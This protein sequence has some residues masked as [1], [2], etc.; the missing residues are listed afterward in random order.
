MA[1]TQIRG[2]NQI[3]DTTITK[4]KL[5]ADFL[6]GSNL[7]ITNGNEDATITG[8]VNPSSAQ[9]AA[10]KS[11]VDALVD[12]SLKSPEA[13]NPTTAGGASADI[14]S[15]ADQGGNTWRYTITDGNITDLGI[16]DSVLI[17]NSTNAAND[18]T[19]T[20]T[21]TNSSTYF[22]VTNASGVAEVTSPATYQISGSYPTEYDSAAVEKGDSFRITSAGTIGN[23]TV[24]AEDLLIALIDTPGQTNTN[25]M[26]AESNRDQATETVLGLVELSTQAE[27]DA[28]TN[29]TTAIT[30]LKLDTYITN[31]GIASLAF[32]N[33]LTNTAGAVKLGGT[34]TG[35]TTI[36]TGDNTLSIES[37]TF[38]GSTII[39]KN[40]FSATV[41]NAVT[42]SSLSASLVTV[43]DGT[44]SSIAVTPS[45]MVVTDNNNTKGLTYNGAYKANFTTYSLV[46]K[47]YV[48][49]TITAA[50][51]TDGAGLLLTGTTLNVGAGNG[52]TVGTDTISVNQ[53]VTS[54]GDIAPVSVGTNGVGL[55]VTVLDGDH[56]T[57]TWN[58]SNSTPDATPT[59]AADTDDLTAHLKGID[60]KF[61]T[62]AIKLTPHY[63][64]TPAI[65]DGVATIAALTNLGS[66][67]TNKV[68]NERVY[69]NGLRQNE[70]SG[71]DYQINNTT[72]V[73][74]F[75]FTLT[76]ADIVTVDYD[77]QDA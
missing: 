76:T 3:K 5:V 53:D 43:D 52:I 4:A 75:E 36:A 6:A 27:A 10:T 63:G 61:A 2:S 45:N 37:T 55:D 35:A 30:P 32:E 23:V 11:Y 14:A 15:I 49:T 9:D 77:K 44:I 59:A 42:V 48:D 28:G 40:H 74:T 24:N 7:N 58:P 66:H 64:E 57:I 67:A 22:D 12:A 65:T 47:D 62:I 1:I 21:A 38:G 60:D 69:L 51:W 70:G 56:L 68:I 72:G 34:L 71:V 29:D 19:F 20:V 16:G 50:T 39:I 26:V 46:D 8:L 73:I 33:G 31:A 54:G 25:W 18:G 13:Y 41:Y 17:A